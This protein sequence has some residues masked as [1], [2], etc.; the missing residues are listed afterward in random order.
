M[1]YLTT[2]FQDFEAHLDATEVRM[3]GVQFQTTAN[4]KEITKH[5]LEPSAKALRLQN[6]GKRQYSLQCVGQSYSSVFLDLS[7]RI[8]IRN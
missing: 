3:G 6:I 5:E 8:G 2:K 4:Y 1:A 7:T